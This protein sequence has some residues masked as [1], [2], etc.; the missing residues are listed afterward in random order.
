MKA[1]KEAKKRSAAEASAEK[2]QESP[3]K[4][5]A[6]SKAL[7]TALATNAMVSDGEADHLVQEAMKVAFEEDQTTEEDNQ[8]IKE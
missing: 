4:R 6:L 1:R 3:N 7:R 8:M 5:L 2:E